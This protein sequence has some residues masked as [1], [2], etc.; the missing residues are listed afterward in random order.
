MLEVIPLAIHDVKL[1][2]QSH[3]HYDNRGIFFEAWRLEQLTDLAAS[4]SPN[5]IE[6]VQGNIS[7]SVPY[8]LR[9][10]HYQTSPQGKFVRCI[11]GSIYDVAVD[12]RRDSPTFKQWVGQKLDARGCEAIYV[13]PG[14]AHGFLAL[15]EGALV[16]YEMTA[17]YRPECDRALRYNCP[18]IGIKWPI[19]PH[20]PLI[21]SAKDRQAK[22]FSELTE[23]DFPQ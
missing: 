22:I 2:K 17:P 1:V 23:E 7:H 21:I 19:G 18:E 11:H 4:T 6:F 12:L 8:V 16:V 10:M 15:E 20:S 3:I 13:P 14:F 9:G 5:A